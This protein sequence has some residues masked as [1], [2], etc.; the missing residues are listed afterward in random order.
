MIRVAKEDLVRAKR[1]TDA[2]K[3]EYDQGKKTI[4][5]VINGVNNGKIGG[6]VSAELLSV[7]ETIKP[8]LQEAYRF[9]EE[10]DTL[11][12]NANREYDNT[13]EDASAALNRNR[14]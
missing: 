6:S 8:T 7:Y 9:F 14:M 5:N 13:T 4:D 10:C 2:G 1:E 12:Q 11:M 3:N